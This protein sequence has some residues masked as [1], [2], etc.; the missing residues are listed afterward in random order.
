M[1]GRKTSGLEGKVGLLEASRSLGCPVWLSMS[2]WNL[3]IP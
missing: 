1:F 2:V 3:S